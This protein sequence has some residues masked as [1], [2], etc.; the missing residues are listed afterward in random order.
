MPRV[1]NYALKITWAQA[2]AKQWLS[3]QRGITASYLHNL[4]FHLS[5]HCFSAASSEEPDCRTSTGEKSKEA[6]GVAHKGNTR[7]ESIHDRY[8][9]FIYPYAA[10]PWIG[11]VK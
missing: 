9:C 6:K 2:E 8:T 1:H 7:V 3:Q 5:G 4:S 10:C 11:H